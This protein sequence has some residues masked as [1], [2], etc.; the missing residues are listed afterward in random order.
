MEVPAEAA[1]RAGADGLAAINTIKSVMNINL[2]TFSS[3]P[4]V[5]GKSPEGG[6]SGK[7]VKPIALRFINDMAKDENLKGVPISG[8]EASKH[9]GMRLNFWHWAVRRSRLPQVL[10][11]MGTGLSRI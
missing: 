1:V 2:Q 8:M 3:A 4:D 7:A 5:D 10:C 11:S 9:G 6:Y